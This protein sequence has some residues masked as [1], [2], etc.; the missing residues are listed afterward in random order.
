LLPHIEPLFNDDPADEG[1]LKNWARILSNASWYMWLKRSYK[2]AED[3]V[4]K[5][6]DA[7][8]RTLGERT[9]TRSSVCPSWHWHCNIRKK[10]EEAEQT[11]RRALARSEKALGRE[12]PETLNSVYCLAFLYHQQKRYC[13]GNGCTV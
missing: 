11:N 5:A 1:L 4:M 2:A 12:Q 3:T 9:R 6:I 7:R 10:Y 8:E 13:G